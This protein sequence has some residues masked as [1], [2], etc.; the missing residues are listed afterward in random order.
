MKSYQKWKLFRKDLYRVLHVLARNHDSN[1]H[2]NTLRRSKV[3][4]GI[5]ANTIE[6]GVN[7][8]AVATLSIPRQFTISSQ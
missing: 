6:S 8:F 3:L 4:S 2:T 1:E 7:R 5:A